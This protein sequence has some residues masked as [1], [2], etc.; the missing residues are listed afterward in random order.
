MIINPETTS[1]CRA[2]HLVSCPPYHVSPAGE[3]I[4]RNDTSRFPYFAYHLYCGPG[5]AG[6]AENPVDICDPYSNP[7]SQE[8]LQLLPHPEW[9]VHGY[10]NRQGDG[11]VR[12][13][14]I[15]KLDVGALSSRLYF[16]QK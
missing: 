12:D 11:W 2:N 5:N 4:Y 9:A 8:I 15:W 1:W 13:P 10:P 6:Y 14:R 3:I 16:Y 7:Q